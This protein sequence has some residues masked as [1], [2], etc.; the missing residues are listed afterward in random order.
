[1][2]EKISYEQKCE[3]LLEDFAKKNNIEIVD[4]EFIKEA[5]QW[6]LRIYIDKDGGV[7]ID[8]CEMVSKYIDPILDEEDFIRETYILEVSSPGLTANLKKDKQLK[9]H[10][11]DYIELNLYKAF[12]EYKSFI[13]ILKEFDDESITLEFELDEIIKFERKNVASIKLALIY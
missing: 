3:K 4:I 1:M 7:N 11:G 9:R 2:S 5:G 12:M 13:G 8:D 10:I 6:Y